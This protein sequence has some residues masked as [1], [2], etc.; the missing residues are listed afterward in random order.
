MVLARTITQFA[1]MLSFT[2]ERTSFI[3]TSRATFQGNT[4]ANREFREA[5]IGWP[6]GQGANMITRNHHAPV[7]SIGLQSRS[8]I[9]EYLS[10]SERFDRRGSRVE[11]TACELTSITML[12]SLEDPRV[13]SAD[14]T[15][16]VN[17]RRALENSKALWV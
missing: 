15:R 13:T 14:L 12:A 5:A 6:A 1:T 3:S 8:G 4:L 11:F 17:Q 10:R 9:R 16:R 7:W 2:H